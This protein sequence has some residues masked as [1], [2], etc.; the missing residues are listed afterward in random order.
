MNVLNNKKIILFGIFFAIFSAS[1]NFYFYSNQNTY[2]LH[3]YLLSNPDVLNNDWLSNTIDGTPVFS[4][5]TSYLFSFGDALA[6]NFNKIF[7]VIFYVYLFKLI[8]R[9][10]PTKNQIELALIILIICFAANFLPILMGLKGQYILGSIYQ[11]SIFGV[12]LLPSLYYYLENQYI[13][14][15]IFLLI[16]TIFHPS[17]LLTSATLGIIFLLFLK[18]YK[19]Q[20]I[21]LS[22]GIIGFIPLI[23]YVYFN[24][25]ASEYSSSASNIL[26]NFR[27]PHHAD[28][29][30]FN[31]YLDRERLILWVIAIFACKDNFL[32]KILLAAFVF[33]CF[34]LVLANVIDSNSFLLLFPMRLSQLILPIAITVVS[35]EIFYCLKN[36]IDRIISER[37]IILCCKLAVSILVILNSA[38]IYKKMNNDLFYNLSSFTSQEDV[39]LI[40]TRSEN[41]RFNLK[42]PVFIDYKN[43]PINHKDITEWKTRLDY[44][45]EF[46]LSSSKSEQQNALNKIKNISNIDYVLTEN[47]NTI[48]INLDLIYQDINRNLFLYKVR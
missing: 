35:I 1:Y 46:Y 22:A 31:Y 27:I 20:L 42:Q 47:P 15:Y 28:L 48:L 6:M 2:L 7:E 37:A 33:I 10:Y 16:A 26:V 24:I 39:W 36:F 40:P 17:L 13:K 14:S 29:S 38:L 9:S 45:S 44:A 18:N 30:N 3:A 4:I 43:H 25:Y 5:F 19:Q 34:Y 12:F 8:Q 32:K 11:P 41:I 21:F 23:L